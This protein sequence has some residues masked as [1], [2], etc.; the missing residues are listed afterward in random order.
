MSPIFGVWYNFEEIAPRERLVEITV[1]YS[2]PSPVLLDILLRYTNP[3]S[4]HLIQFLLDCSTL[5]EIIAL[6]QI[7]GDKLL[8]QL[9]KVTRTWCYS[10]H[11]DRL[12]LLGRWRKY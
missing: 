10:I 5:P 6:V 3:Q 9:F 7:H 4:S 11:R 1:K 2:Q 8:H 12:K